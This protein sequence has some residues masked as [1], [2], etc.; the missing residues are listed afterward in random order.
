[1]QERS[2]LLRIFAAQP[3][4]PGIARKNYDAALFITGLMEALHERMV[5]CGHRWHGKAHGPI[6][7]A[8]PQAGNCERLAAK[9]PD[10]P[11]HG[12]ARLPI[13]F[14]ESGRAYEAK[15]ASLPVRCKRE[16][17]FPIVSVRAFA[18]GK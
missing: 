14:V 16:L 11:A 4:I 18:V 13:R 12:L 1:M 10:L 15:L 8:A 6:G 2:R 9:K 5:A 7:P 3:I 17:S